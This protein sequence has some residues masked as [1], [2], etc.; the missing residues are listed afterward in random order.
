MSTSIAF[1]ASDA[2][3][4]QA[5]FRALTRR[6]E[7]VRPAEAGVIV[8]L[9]GDGMMLNVLLKWG[10]KGK[11][12][13][14]MN[15]GTVGFLLN[16]YCEDGLLDRIGAASAAVIHPLRM[17]AVTATGTQYTGFAINEVSLLRQTRMTALIR[18]LV[19]GRERMPALAC[20]GVLVSTPAGST[21][22]NLSAHGPILPL[23][24]P[25]HALTPICPFRPRRWRGALLPEHVEVSFEVLESDKRPVSATAGD[26]EIRHVRVVNVTADRGTALTL[27]F[28]PEHHL[29][30]R[31]LT[32]QFN[33]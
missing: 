6:Y 14:G 10:P 28:D 22:Y 8:V 29:E 2:D 20:D 13:Y 4:A 32:E 30:E 27:L 33:P 3:D 15:K 24:T 12:I 21:A 17:E 18:I 16:R 7:H 1:V 26:L 11:R 19:D 9:G 31:I 23:G 25:L 5:A